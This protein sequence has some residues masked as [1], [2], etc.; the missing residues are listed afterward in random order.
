MP[1]SE[2][3][4]CF[5]FVLPNGATVLIVDKTNGPKGKWYVFAA[6]R[7]GSCLSR[8]EFVSW[9]LDP[10]TMEC[11]EGIYGTNPAYVFEKHAQRMGDDYK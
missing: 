2:M 1:D 10:S 9:V 3:S 7:K 4:L 11:S 6:Q 8:P 5:G